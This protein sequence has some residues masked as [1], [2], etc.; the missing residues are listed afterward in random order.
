MNSQSACDDSVFNYSGTMW[1]PP[2][3]MKPRVT[4]LGSDESDSLI[5]ATS[6][7]LIEGKLHYTRHYASILQ[8]VR[9]VGSQY[10]SNHDA[11]CGN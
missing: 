11:Q 10:L 3:M 7:V 4:G 2:D 9:C 1:L 6:C 5:L 8:P